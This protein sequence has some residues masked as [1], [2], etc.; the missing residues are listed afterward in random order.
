LPT[1]KVFVGVLTY[2]VDTINHLLEALMQQCKTNTDKDEFCL[3][4]CRV[5]V[6]REEKILATTLA[7]N[8]L[9][10]WL[11]DGELIAIP[12]PNALNIHVYDGHTH[13][14][15]SLQGN[16]RARGSSNVALYSCENHAQLIHLASF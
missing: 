3:G 6:R 1:P 9:E 10:P 7:D 11:I 16:D 2:E 8:L 14:I 12:R 13:A 5:N 4:N 15:A